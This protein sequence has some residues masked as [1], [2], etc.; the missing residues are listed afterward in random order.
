MFMVI[1][2]ILLKGINLFYILRI[3]EGNLLTFFLFKSN[4]EIILGVNHCNIPRIV[5][6][7]VDCILRE[8]IDMENVVAKRMIN[9]CKHVQVSLLEF[10]FIKYFI[11]Y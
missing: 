4:N 8:G 11:E 3:Q 9:I 1:Y 2:V 6:V 5:Q 10:K 7:I